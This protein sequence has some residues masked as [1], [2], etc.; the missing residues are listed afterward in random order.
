MTVPSLFLMGTHAVAKNVSLDAWRRPVKVVDYVGA[1][2][3]VVSG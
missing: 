2:V 1:G 3:G